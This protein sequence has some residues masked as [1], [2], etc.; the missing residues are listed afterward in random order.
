MGNLRSESF[1][2]NMGSEHSEALPAQYGKR[3]NQALACAIW[4]ASKASPCVRNMGSE[5]S[6]PLR[7]RDVRP[8]AGARIKGA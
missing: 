6:E 8:S 3:A 4:E 2:R 5:Q 7:A 1:V